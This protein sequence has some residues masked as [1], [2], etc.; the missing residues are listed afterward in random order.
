[1][2]LQSSGH[3]HFQCPF[4][5]IFAAS[6]HWSLTL[7]RGVFLAGQSFL[8]RRRTAV[9]QRGGAAPG[10]CSKSHPAKKTSNRRSLGKPKKKCRSTVTVANEHRSASVSKVGESYAEKKKLVFPCMQML[11]TEVSARGRESK[12]S[13]ILAW[14]QEICLSSRPPIFLP[15]SLQRWAEAAS[16]LHGYCVLDI[17][18]ASLLLGADGA[19][20]VCDT[21]PTQGT[22]QMQPSARPVSLLLE[23]AQYLLKQSSLRLPSL[24]MLCLPICLPAVPERPRLPLLLV[25]RADAAA[26]AALPHACFLPV[27][28]R[29]CTSVV[30]PLTSESAALT[31]L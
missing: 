17:S 29:P 15:S 27:V 5:T 31:L 12:R 4:A 25:N 19:N 22:A 8:P 23:A 9:T 26:L 2:T 16:F 1:M 13:R 18:N 24:R 20:C 21:P 3:A 7:L 30:G 14:R 11:L 10:L 28:Q 6:E